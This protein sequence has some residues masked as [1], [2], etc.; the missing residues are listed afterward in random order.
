MDHSS[1]RPIPNRAQTLD[2]LRLMG[3]YRPL[4]MLPGDD[5][6]YGARWLLDGGEVPPGIAKYLIDGGFVAPTGTTGFGARE[7]TLTESGRRLRDNGLRWWAGLGLLQRWWVI[8]R[9]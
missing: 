1:P 8:V 6:G 2:V 9:G 5:D 3:N 4:L 7:L